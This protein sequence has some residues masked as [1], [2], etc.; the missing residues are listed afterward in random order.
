MRLFFLSL[1]SALAGT[2]AGVGAL[3]AAYFVAGA[4]GAAPSG[5]D[6]Q[7]FALLMFVPAFALCLLLYAPALIWL[8]RKRRSCEPPG[9][10]TLT[11][12]LLLN[13][14]V[15]LVLLLALL[16]GG[17]FFGA[18]EAALF[19]AAFAAAGAT[20]GRGFVWWCRRKTREG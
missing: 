18:G 8:S 9:F 6:V 16:R 12:A 3:Y 13:L 2:L 4:G 10:F 5:T 19:A 20:F 1:S 17:M 11:P 14:P 15:F 7:S